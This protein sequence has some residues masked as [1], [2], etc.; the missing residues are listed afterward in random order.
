[1]GEIAQARSEATVQRM[2]GVV[3]GLA[4]DPGFEG[5]QEEPVEETSGAP[6]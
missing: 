4:Y 1:M 3:R 5:N 2:K 6:A